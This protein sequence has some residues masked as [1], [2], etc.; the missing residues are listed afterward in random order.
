MCAW[1]TTIILKGTPALHT[2]LFVALYTSSV[3]VFHLVHIACAKVTVH[4]VFGPHFDKQF[5][6][7]VCC[8]ALIL[9]SAARA[10]F[11]SVPD[12]LL[13]ADEPVIIHGVVVLPLI[14][15]NSTSF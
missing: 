2:L 1:S 7:T 6:Q 10:L 12:M 8:M 5:K 4:L 3:W 13:V 14:K 11:S 9:S 15:V